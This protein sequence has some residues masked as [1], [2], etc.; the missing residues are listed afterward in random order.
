MS[1]Y[2]YMMDE[3]LKIAASTGFTPLPPKMDVESFSIPPSSRA[4]SMNAYNRGLYPQANNAVVSEIGNAATVRPGGYAQQ[5]GLAH[6]IPVQA[7][8][9]IQAPKRGMPHTKLAPTVPASGAARMAKIPKP[10]K[11][12]GMFGKALK[13]VL[14]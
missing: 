11:I 12:P 6:T 4:P 8:P 9:S 5:A 7:Q 13:G 1:I 10:P 3:L 2:G 14:S